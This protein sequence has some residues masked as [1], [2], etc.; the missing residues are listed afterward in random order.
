MRL[1]LLAAVL[2]AACSAPT[3][4]TPLT[5]EAYVWQRQWTPAVQEAAASFDGDGLTALAAEVRWDGDTPMIAWVDPQVLTSGRAVRVRVPP[6][7]V[8]V[9]EALGPV[10]TA[11]SDAAPGT[12]I[13][14]DMDLPSRRLG[15]YTAWITELKGKVSGPLV[16]T[17]LP[18]WLDH[19]EFAHLVAAADGVVLQ[20][21]WLDPEDPTGPLLSPSAERYVEKMAA[22]NVPFRV[23]LPAYGHRIWTRDGRLVGVGSEGDSR[24]PDVE[25][26]RVMAD[27]HAVSALLETW[28]V[29]HPAALTGVVWFRLPTSQDQMAW[30]SQTLTAVREGRELVSTVQTERVLGESGAHQICLRNS[31]TLSWTPTVVPVPDARLGGGRPGWQWSPALGGLRP[32]GGV[33]PLLPDETRCIGWVDPEGGD[34]E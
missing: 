29:R 13:H 19:A 8:D 17:A 20:V 16:I 2:C 31:G 12:E 15:N 33:P 4:T 24:P 34:H 28:R 25:E 14:L 3:S 30:P 10:L 9:V 6:E 27:P 11:V 21:H 26:T 32:Q 1:T 5:H 7:G 18:T 22:F 23:A